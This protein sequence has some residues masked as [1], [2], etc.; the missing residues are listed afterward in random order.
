MFSICLSSVVMSA[1]WRCAF[2]FWLTGIS[3][4]STRNSRRV[5]Q[6]FETRENEYHSYWTT[7]VRQCKS[8]QK[9]YCTHIL[10]SNRRGRLGESNFYNLSKPFVE[11]PAAIL[12]CRTLQCGG[13]HI[14]YYYHLHSD[15]GTGD[16]YLANFISRCIFDFDW[17]QWS[18]GGYLAF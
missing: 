15:I 8:I 9:P 11:E 12:D 18:V 2:H 13:K 7:G 17:V 3:R 14:K 6:T 5:R 4:Q 1:L 16:F 10:I